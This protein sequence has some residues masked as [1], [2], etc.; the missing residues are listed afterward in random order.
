M[1]AA[2]QAGTGTVLDRIVAAKS[3]ALERARSAVPLSEVRRSAE[4]GPPVTDFGKRLSAPG[5]S[6]IAE[7]KRASPSGGELMPDLDPAEMAAAYAGAGAAAISVLTEE[8]FFRGSIDDLR[9]ARTAAELVTG[10]HPLRM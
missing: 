8:E 2:R 5:I 6:L 7:M 3:T 1:S 10:L 4:N 9:A